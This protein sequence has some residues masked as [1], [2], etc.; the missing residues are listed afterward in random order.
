M[1]GLLWAFAATFPLV[2]VVHASDFRMSDWQFWAIGGAALWW[3]IVGGLAD[4][5]EKERENR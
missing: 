5:S 1:K 2:V 3:R 4:R